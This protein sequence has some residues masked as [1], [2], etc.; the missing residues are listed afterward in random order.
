MWPCFHRKQT[1]HPDSEEL[2]IQE[3]RDEGKEKEEEEKKDEQEVTDEGDGGSVKHQDVEV[4][5]DGDRLR[6]Y[7]EESSDWPR[8]RVCHT[9]ERA[10][11]IQRTVEALDITEEGKLKHTEGHVHEQI[12]Q[13]GSR[14][15]DRK[16][17]NMQCI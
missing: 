16:V 9:H 3:D 11:P 13:Y 4:K 15:V 17:S 7:E 8:E 5:A 10:I 1:S 14:Q 2:P 6:D 12:N